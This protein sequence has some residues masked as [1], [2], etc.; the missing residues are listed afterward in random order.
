MTACPL[1]RPMSQRF[2][3][4]VSTKATSRSRAEGLVAHPVL[5]HLQDPEETEDQGRGDQR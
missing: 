2:T 1:P 4:T 5:K 3:G